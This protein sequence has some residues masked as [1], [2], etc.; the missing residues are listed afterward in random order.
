[1]NLT[2]LVVVLALSAILVLLVRTIIGKEKGEGVQT[3]LG[4]PDP[5]QPTATAV[6]STA[7]GPKA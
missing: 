7:Q 4:S 3:K 2:Y 5:A 1:M 6:E